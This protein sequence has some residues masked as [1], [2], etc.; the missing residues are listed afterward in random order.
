MSWELKGTNVLHIYAQD[1]WHQEAYIVGNKEGLLELRNAI[2][3][4]LK[5]KEAVAHVFPTDGEG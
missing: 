1:A 5:S 3:E 2:D 4:A